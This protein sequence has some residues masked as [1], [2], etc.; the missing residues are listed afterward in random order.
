[1]LREPVCRRAWLS[2]CTIPDPVAA[3]EQMRRV[4]KPGGKLFLVEH[5]L[6]KDPGVQRWQRRPNGIQNFM[7]GGC[8]L[9]R[10]IPRLVGAAVFT[11]DEVDQ[12]YIQGPPKPRRVRDT[13]YR[14]CGVSCAI[15]DRRQ[16]SART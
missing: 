8:N 2:T 14:D 16:E 1:M 3:L 7:C 13:G 4:L 6:F 10:D 12:Y 15:G 9:N 11:F 5:G